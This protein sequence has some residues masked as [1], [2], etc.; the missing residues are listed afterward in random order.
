MTLS[1]RAD[2]LVDLA[3]NK[4]DQLG[5]PGSAKQQAVI[6]IL[7]KEFWKA[8]DGEARFAQD[9][10]WFRHRALEYVFGKPSLNDL[11]MACHSTLI[12]ELGTNFGGQWD[13]TE[14]GEELLLE[15]FDELTAK[16]PTQQE[17]F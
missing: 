7:F 11:D 16:Y 5:L 8:Q 2:V 14:R 3:N 10:T 13:L 1:E 17:L 15:V 9:A 12:D 6:C 4:I